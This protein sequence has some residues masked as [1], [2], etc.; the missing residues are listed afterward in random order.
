V[1]RDAQQDSSAD[2]GKF[3]FHLSVI[4]HPQT[5]GPIFKVGTSDRLPCCQSATSP[6]GYYWE[7]DLW[8]RQQH[9]TEIQASEIYCGSFRFISVADRPSL[10]HRFPNTRKSLSRIANC[11]LESEGMS[12]VTSRNVKQN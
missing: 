7:A 1:Y 12:L 10:D 2:C 8:K 3:Y 4:S 6:V 11:N 5:F 9:F